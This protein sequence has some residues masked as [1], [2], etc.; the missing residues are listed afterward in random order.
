LPVEEESRDSGKGDA[1]AVPTGVPVQGFDARCRE[2]VAE[3]ARSLEIQPAL[4]Y[5]WRRA[6]QVQTPRSELERELQAEK[7]R[8]K[9]EL[10]EQEEN[11][12]TAACACALAIGSRYPLRVPV[13]ECADVFNIAW[14]V[15][16]T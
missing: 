16:L 4:I 9:R 13:C 10:A 7:A 15:P 11:Q 6:V 8:L 2:G 12:S 5:N 3:A 14:A 1:Q